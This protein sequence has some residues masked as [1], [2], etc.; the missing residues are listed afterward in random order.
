MKSMKIGRI[1]CNSITGALL[2]FLILGHN[3]LIHAQCALPV[4]GIQ[5]LNNGFDRDLTGEVITYY[6]SS[7]YF[8]KDAL[9]TRCTDGKKIITWETSILPQSLDQDYYYFRWL[10]GHS[11]GTSGADRKFELFVNGQSSLTFITPVKTKPPYVWVYRNADS[12]ALVFSAMKSDVHNDL[13]GEMYLRVPKKLLKPGQPL[14]L[15][16]CGH[17]ENSNDWCM[18]FRSPYK[19]K[20]IPVITP[21]LVQTPSGVKQQLMVYVDHIYP[22]EGFIEVTLHEKVTKV[23]VVEGFNEVCINIDTVTSPVMLK[24]GI[25]VGDT[26]VRS[27]TV[28]QGPVHRREVDIIH[29]SHNDIGYSHRQ[30]E[31]IKIQFQNLLKALDCIERTKDYPAGSRFVWNVETL[32][33]VEFFLDHASGKDKQRF[34]TAVKAGQ[35]C[36]T[37]FYGGVMTGLCSPEELRWINEYGVF[38]RNTYDFPITTAMLSDIPGMSW[39]IADALTEDSIRYISNGPNYIPTLPDR[40][41]RIGSIYKYL[42]DVPFYWKTTTGK[43]SV[44]VWTAGC[45]YSAFHQISVPDLGTKI[46][47]KLCAYLNELDTDLYPY[48]LIQLRYTIKSDNGPVDTTLSDFVRNW[49]NTYAVSYTHLTLPTN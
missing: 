20:V 46:K 35:I 3:G 8:A 1:V 14:L 23:P 39:S 38:L 27:F 15:S 18:V 2:L 10:A 16:M 47:E 6:S 31:V 9:L 45:G 33:P 13:F 25:K 21:F 12:V 26:V 37:A 11:S 17:A 30:D 32:W 28:M 49:N 34:I 36:L 40:G 48:E 22:A 44:L 19:E 41:D 43:D 7:P 4:L 29:H 24:I 5:Q 42:G